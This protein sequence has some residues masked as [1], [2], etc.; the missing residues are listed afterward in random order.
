MGQDSSGSYYLGNVHLQTALGGAG[1]SYAGSNI[2]HVYHKTGNEV[3]VTDPQLGKFAISAAA[4][5]AVR[6]AVLRELSDKLPAPFVGLLNVMSGE[7]DLNLTGRVTSATL[8][9][10]KPVGRDETED[11]MTLRKQPITREGAEALARRAAEELAFLDRLEDKYGAE[12][13]DGAVIRFTKQF[14]SP[15]YGYSAPT[16]QVVR[17]TYAGIRANGKWYL[18][19]AKGSQSWSWFE[20]LN[21]LDE[22]V[23]AEHFVVLSSG[24]DPDPVDVTERILEHRVVYDEPGS[25]P[26]GDIDAATTEFHDAEYDIISRAHP[27]FT[28]NQIEAFIAD[29]HNCAKCISM[30][31]DVK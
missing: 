18:T 1:G 12:P 29:E 28:P 22:G 24:F 10:D 17:Y 13:Q 7:Q 30:R 8:E 23:P 15:S 4:Y 25:V 27:R 3:R 2:E 21:W 19:G 6:N 16:S 20:L 11:E 31:E 5:Q 14:A 26:G 9:E